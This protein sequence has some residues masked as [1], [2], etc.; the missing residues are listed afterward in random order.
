MNITIVGAGPAGLYFALL[1]KRQNPTHRIRV[2]EQN[3]RDATYGFG[4]VFS[5]GAL[6]FLERDDADF[7]TAL[8]AAM[9]R[10]PEQT[11]VHRDRA[12]RIDGNGFAAIGRLELLSLLQDL[13]AAADVD[14]A[15]ESPVETIAAID[16]DLI[17]GADGVNSVVRSHLADQFGP[18]IADLS[19]KFV[20]YG[21]EQQFDTLT[22]TF[23]ETEHGAFVAHHYRYSPAMSTFI[24]ECEAATWQRA[25]FAT[26]SENQSR[27]TC[28]QIFAPD[29]GG[30]PLVSNK[31][32]W[33]NFPVVTNRH[34]THGNVVLIGDA[35]R[36]VHFSIG[37]GTRLALEDAI[38]LARAFAETGNDVLLAL[39][40]FEQTRRP[41]VDKILA[42][43]AGSF[44]WYE[45]FGGLMHLAPYPLAY[46]YM[47]RSGRMTHDRL[48]DTAPRFMAEYEAAQIDQIE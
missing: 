29:L 43:A 23:R 28:E 48:R 13:C 39:A 25:G 4:V 24:V 22:L 8:T 18:E 37:S 16:A 10:W 17:V 45:S 47:M 20:W 42:G 21:T 19:N 41:I 35:L 2:I 38:F 30:H 15:Y 40:R 11:I 36:T 44:S 14:I 32:L 5:E 46:S 31:S 12:I 26:M 7:Y 6:S 27:H 1:M 3:P 34:W 33:R 9:E